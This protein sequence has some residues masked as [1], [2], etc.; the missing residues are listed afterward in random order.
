MSK[1]WMLMMGHCHHIRHFIMLNSIHQS[2]VCGDQRCAQG[3]V[4]IPT[5]APHICVSSITPD[6][7]RCHQCTASSIRCSPF[8]ASCRFLKRTPQKHNFTCNS[9]TSRLRMMMAWY[10]Q[11]KELHFIAMVDVYHIQKQRASSTSLIGECSHLTNMRRPT[12]SLSGPLNSPK[13]TQ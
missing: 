7:I 12:Y 1:R 6:T 5:L 11:N 8:W 4:S 10:A 9:W 2:Q 3:I 13:R